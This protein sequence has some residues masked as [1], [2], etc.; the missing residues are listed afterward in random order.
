M[1]LRHQL[2]GRETAPAARQVPEPELMPQAYYGPIGEY[3]MHLADDT[4]AHP[5]AMLGSA[6]AAAGA[7]I[8][9]TPYWMIDGTPHHA[10]FFVL[11]CGPTA[12]ARKSTAMQHGARNLLQL[13]DPDFASARVKAGLSSGEG[14]IDEVRDATPDSDTV[15]RKGEPISV[16]GDKGVTDKRLLL[17]E[18]E[19][20]GVF[21]KAD[22]QGNALSDVLREAWDGRKL[23]TITRTNRVSATGAHINV[24]GCITP[25]DLR[26]T[27]NH[28]DLHNGLLN[29]FLLVWTNRVRLL[30]HGE[31]A[32]RPPADL[33]RRLHQGVDAGRRIGAIQWTPD[34]ADLWTDVY[35]E[36]SA[37]T[38]TGV[39]MSLLARGAPQVRRLAML[40]AVMD[41]TPS[42][43]LAH[44][45]AALAFWTYCRASV[46]LVYRDAD[47]L[48]GRGR[49]ILDALAAAGEAGLT[50]SQIREVVGTNSVSEEQIDTDLGH[51]R[52]A[53]LASMHRRPT[54]GRPAEVWTHAHHRAETAALSSLTSLSSSFTRTG[55]A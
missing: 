48:S 34:A 38:A 35:P 47:S 27:V 52:E 15:N 20:G 32:A 29:R 50:R 31:P 30:P 49:R 45:E 9:R 7:L 46:A 39:V 53:G 8:G 4:E 11:L 44:L 23:G 40:Y 18:D 10:R 51:L 19:L 2:S 42:V 54:R 26:E 14:L 16:P 25:A 36:L 12:T 3:V 13:L 28:A 55:A 17:L 43:S 41:G 21:K 22:R 1:S 6:I 33:L 24:V 37:P 5:A